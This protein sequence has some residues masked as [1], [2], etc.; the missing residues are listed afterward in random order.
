VPLPDPDPG[1]VYAPLTAKSSYFGAWGD[2][3]FL[4]LGY[5]ARL[6]TNFGYTLGGGVSDSGWVLRNEHS[7]SAIHVFVEVI[8]DCVGY[9][10]FYWKKG[11]YLTLIENR[12]I[13]YQVDRV[14]AVLS[15]TV[16]PNSWVALWYNSDV[17]S[18]PTTQPIGSP[19]EYF[20]REQ[21]GNEDLSQVQPT[22][23][24]YRHRIT[25]DVAS[26]EAL[27]S[28]NPISLPPKGLV[29]LIA[30]R[31]DGFIYRL[32]HQLLNKFNPGGGSG[33]Y[34]GW[35]FGDPVRGSSA[36]TMY[37]ESVNGN[38][39]LY[40][41][42]AN[43][44]WDTTSHPIQFEVQGANLLLKSEGGAYLAWPTKPWDGSAYDGA[45]QSLETTYSTSVSDAIVWQVVFR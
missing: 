37:Q 20:V 8:V 44:S 35:L 6:T 33:Y 3:D 11:G 41:P 5:D 2:N 21:F 24:P 31:G 10:G 19:L 27:V 45:L 7:Q 23:P 25:R 40:L 36:R 22:H 43:P 39:Y 17:N 4:G 1:T 34:T 29:D 16:F 9:H 30:D 14:V 13:D 26:D 42:V 28:Y 38:G 18:G 32:Y 12:V 15:A